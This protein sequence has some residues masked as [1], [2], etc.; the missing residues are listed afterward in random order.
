MGYDVKNDNYIGYIYKITNNINGKVYIGQTR[1]TVDKRWYDHVH[2]SKNC[3]SMVIGKAI[4]KYGEKNFTIATLETVKEKSLDLLQ[5]KLDELEIA[6]IKKYNSYIYNGNGYNGTKGGQGGTGRVYNPIVSYDINGNKLYDFD[7]FNSAALYYKI[8]VSTI[9]K[10]CNGIQYNYNNRIVFRYNSDSFDKYPVLDPKEN[11]GVYQFD[12]NGN[13]VNR[14]NNLWQAYEKTGIQ[15]DSMNIIDDPN[16]LRGGYWWSFGEE[17]KY[18]GMSTYRKVDAYNGTNLE[19]IGTYNSIV[20]CAKTLGVK[21]SG[22]SSNCLGKC[23]TS[24]G[25]IF[26]YHGDS[27]DKYDYNTNYKGP[28]GAM[29]NKYSKNDE[30]ICSYD[31]MREACEDLGIPFSGGLSA[32][33]LGKQK[34]SHGYKWFYADDPNQPDKSAIA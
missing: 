18:C 9:S 1:Q 3:K 2:H 6:Y 14:Y 15:F 11:Y 8:S 7:N 24:Q 17:F 28:K 4:N 30:Y 25:Y 16:T 23:K 22:I 19:F 32:C 10:I 21:P 5:K 29:V 27:L 26:R 34:S 20:E 13:I 31:T 12:I 33:C